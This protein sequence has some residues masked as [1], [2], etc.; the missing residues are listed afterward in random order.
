MVEAGPGKGGGEKRKEGEMGRP[1]HP[2]EVDK[3]LM[4]KLSL[5]KLSDQGPGLPTCREGPEELGRKTRLMEALEERLKGLGGAAQERSVEGAQKIDQGLLLSRREHLPLPFQRLR[6]GSQRERRHPC[7]VVRTGKL[8][9]SRLPLGDQTV[10]VEAH[11]G[12]VVDELVGPGGDPSSHEGVGSLEYQADI[13]DL[14]VFG[15][16]DASREGPG[17]IQTDR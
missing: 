3:G 14:Y 12:Q 11:V 10:E 1:P 15:T 8:P 16:H 6:R 13:G 9:R 2:E 7:H 17:S 4:G 5:V